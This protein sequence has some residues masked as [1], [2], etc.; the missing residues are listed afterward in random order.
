MFLLCTSLVAYTLVTRRNLDNKNTVMSSCSWSGAK[1]NYNG[2]G[3]NAWGTSASGMTDRKVTIELNDCMFTACQSTGATESGVTQGSGGG[4]CVWFGSL[5]MRRCKFIS[6]TAYVDGGGACVQDGELLADDC[7]FNGCSAR[8]NGGACAAYYQAMS[9]TRYQCDVQF[10]NSRIQDCTTQGS[11][12]LYFKDDTCSNTFSGNHI[13]NCVSSGQSPSILYIQCQTLTFAGNDFVLTLES[14]TASAIQMEI[15]GEE[16]VIDNCDFANG[17][18]KLNHF[19]S[20]NQEGIW[21]F[22]DCSFSNIASTRDGGGI[23][24]NGRGNQLTIEVHKCTFTNVV[25]EYSG[26]AIFVNYVSKFTI[27]ECHIESCSNENSWSNVGGGG[28][29]HIECEAVTG[30]VSGCVFVNNNSPLNGQSLQVMY[31]YLGD[32]TFTVMNCTFKGHNVGSMLF[33]GKYRDNQH[34]TLKDNDD[35]YTIDNCTFEGNTL[36][37]D[38]VRNACGVVCAKSTTGVTYNECVF[39]S[40]TA[41]KGVVSA[42]NVAGTPK[43]SFV[44]CTFDTCSR[45]VAC[46]FLGDSCGLAEISLDSC[47]FKACNC[48]LF[49]LGTSGAKITCT[50]TDVVESQLSGSLI[51]GSS[52]TV[53]ISYST[54]VKV[55]GGSDGGVLSLTN[56]RDSSV[57]SCTFTECT[58]SGRGGAVFLSFGSQSGLC[59]VENCTFAKC[60]GSRGQALHLLF[61]GESW[62]SEDP[63]QFDVSNCTFSNSGAEAIAYYPIFLEWS[64]NTGQTYFVPVDWTVKSLIFRDID[65]KNSDGII[66]IWSST[67]ITYDNCQV[68]DCTSVYGSEPDHIKD[69]GGGLI[70]PCYGTNSGTRPSFT[71]SSCVFDRCQTNINS[72]IC[73]RKSMPVESVLIENCYFTDITATSEAAVLNPLGLAKNVAIVSCVF[74]QCSGKDDAAVLDIL[75]DT[76]SFSGNVFTLSV[77]TSSALH[78]ALNTKSGKLSLTG[79]TFNNSGSSVTGRF[80]SIDDEHQYVEF[81]KCHFLDIGSESDGAGLK[82]SLTSDQ[83]RLVA[84]ECEFSGCFCTGSGGAIHGQNTRS[85]QLDEC[86]FDS[87]S[88]LRGSEPA[89]SYAGGGGLFIN[90][91]TNQATLSNCRFINNMSPQNGQSILL[92]CQGGTQFNRISFSTCTFLEHETGS[93]ICFAYV[94]GESLVESNQDYVLTSCVFENNS[95]AGNSYLDDFGFFN[96]NSTG[97]VKYEYCSFIN[98]RLSQ[99]HV[100]EPLSDFVDSGI[101]V[102]RSKCTIFECE[103]DTCGLVNEV[104]GGVIFVKGT[105]SLIVESTNFTS[106]TTS[107]VNTIGSDVTVEVDLCRFDNCISPRTPSVFSVLMINGYNRV[108]SLVISNCSIT[109]CT[110]PPNGAFVHVRAKSSRFENIKINNGDCSD[111]SGFVLSLEQGE[112]A[113]FDFCSFANVQMGYMIQGTSTTGGTVQCNNCSFNSITGTKRGVAVNGEYVGDLTLAGCEFTGIISNGASVS[114]SKTNAILLE[115][116]FDGCN[117]NTDGAGAVYFGNTFTSARIERCKFVN[118][119]CVNNCGQSLHFVMDNTK[120]YDMDIAFCTFREHNAGVPAIV[121]LCYSGTSQRETAYPYPVTLQNCFFQDS[122]TGNLG[123]AHVLAKDVVYDSCEFTSISSG[124]NFGSRIVA[125]HS[126]SASSTL[127]HCVFNKCTQSSQFSGILYFDIGTKV[128]VIVEDL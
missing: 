107:G 20:M 92:V 10:L 7:D 95:V 22:S 14:T 117:S 83:A 124:G 81:T 13:S 61:N 6:C 85:I 60:T 33:F 41:T 55:Q 128:D 42:S 96:G 48:P 9:T 38:D 123:V 37:G 35:Q 69:K 53:T 78:L 56:V 125:I 63:A 99:R 49:N 67:S 98:N 105:S 103:F 113:S 75:V 112:T 8:G 19:L 94:D 121:L 27:T 23:M 77:T 11:Y 54:F 52:Q 64:K 101:L 44:A 93:I 43:C 58:S 31:P 2:G 100:G 4:V 73:F 90:D 47:Q 66:G 119:A 70:M 46:V 106:C 28:G 76:L 80:I 18:Q 82:L 87:C 118:N 15:G 32:R 5:T 120:Q 115:T 104:R 74:S 127:R 21:K 109:G 89:A 65:I 68:I 51:S 1:N 88:C 79:C 29:V 114:I 24:A 12:L 62:A 102:V 97:V 34:N 86:T 3:L 50:D 111:C 57:T 91:G 122:V 25:S 72:L 30:V 36:N 59:K 45:N 16:K 40:N 71:L 116:S 39:R 126:E 17:G 26:G 110:G 84:I 108:T